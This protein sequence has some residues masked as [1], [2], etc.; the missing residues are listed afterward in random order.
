MRGISRLAHELGLST[1]TVSRALNN[2]PGVN[3]RTRQ[4]V[5][6]AAQRLGY[7]PNQAAR[8]LASGRTGAIGFMFEVYPEVAVIGDNF[9]LGVIDGIQSVLALAWARSRWCC[10]APGGSPASPIWTVGSPED[11]STG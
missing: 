9:Y 3:G 10:P 5:L 6:D 8:T 4:L 1:G 7:Q 11:W 2:K